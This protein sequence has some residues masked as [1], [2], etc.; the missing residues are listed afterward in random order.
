MMTH[1]DEKPYQCNH[2]GKAFTVKK[3]LINHLR[4][5][6]GKKLYQC[7][8]CDRTFSKFIILENIWMHTLERIHF[9][10]TYVVKLLQKIVFLHTIWR[11]ILGKTILLQ[12]LWHVFHLENP[13]QSPN[14]MHTGENHMSVT[15]VV[16]LS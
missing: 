9:I 5:H 1:T 10:V 12:I 6:L 7:S 3:S 11:N 2:C 13:T 4:I 14:I 16:R 15:N 8:H